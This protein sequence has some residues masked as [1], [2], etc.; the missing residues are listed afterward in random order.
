MGDPNN[1]REKDVNESRFVRHTIQY[2]HTEWI[3]SNNNIKIRCVGVR[4]DTKGRKYDKDLDPSN[5]PGN[6]DENPVSWNGVT[7]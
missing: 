6:Y 4:G 5:K 7:P 2:D 3:G 1:N